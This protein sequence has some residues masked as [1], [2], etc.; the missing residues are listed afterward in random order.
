VVPPGYSTDRKGAVAEFIQRGLTSIE[1]GGSLTPA[2]E[3][4]EATPSIPI[5]GVAQAASA[6][7][8]QASDVHTN[9][10]F[11]I[12]EMLAQRL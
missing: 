9:R 11:D 7:A 5:E 3:L 10:E 6:P 1:A 12:L 2:R 8:V 4:P